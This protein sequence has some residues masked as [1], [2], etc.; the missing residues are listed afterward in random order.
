M[1]DALSC[2]AFQPEPARDLLRRP[3]EFEAGEHLRPE[4]GIAVEAG[5]TPA[6]SDGPVPGRSG[7]GSPAAGRYCVSAREQWSMARDPEL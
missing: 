4:R 7:A 1:G 6:A 3:A 5:A 2:P